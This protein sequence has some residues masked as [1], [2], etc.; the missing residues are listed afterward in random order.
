MKTPN[1]NG[2]WVDLVILLILLYYSF[3]AF[4]YG[5]FY[6]L[7]DFASFLGS[8]LISLYA[9]KFVAT[10]L[11]ANFNLPSSFNNAFAFI[12]TVFILEIALQSLFTFLIKKLPKKVL[13]NKFNKYLGLAISLAQ[14]VVLISFLLTA[15]IALPIK[16]QV[17][18]DVSE[19][20][21]GSYILKQTSGIEKK[22]DEIFGGVINDALTYFTVEPNSKSTIALKNGI[23][24]L[25]ID[26]TSET[27]MFAMVNNER[28]KV[29]A[30]TLTWEPRLVVVARNYAR[31]MWERHYFSHYS[32]EGKNVADR[33]DA[34]GIQYQIVGENLAMAP[35]VQ[36]AM[37]GL[38]NSQGH[39]ENILNPKFKK[40]GIGVID[41]GFYGKMF[42]QIFTN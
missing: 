20:K 21:I 19:S 5:F 28:S 31:D 18:K 8:L 40:V 26:T 39:R 4:K 12:I 22:I 17:K 23:D 14:G 16:P 32:P 15:I 29:G 13:E 11:K 25:T 35:T 3:E 7:A 36:T 24:K 27:Q 10:F 38:M 30:S 34:A 42:V 6:L 37:T 1:L 9:Y 2:N 41:N 33:L